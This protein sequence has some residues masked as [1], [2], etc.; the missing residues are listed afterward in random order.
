MSAER[1]LSLGQ[2]FD[3]TNPVVTVCYVADIF[4]VIISRF[5]DATLLRSEQPFL[6]YV[7]E[8][9]VVPYGDHPDNYTVLLPAFHPGYDG[10][11][12]Q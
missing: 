1:S 3:I 6:P 4:S 5:A 10:Y 8:L 12:D 9:Q 11:G 7:G 2:Y